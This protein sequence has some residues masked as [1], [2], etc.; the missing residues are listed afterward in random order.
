MTTL[1]QHRFL[2]FMVGQNLSCEFI[3]DSGLGVFRKLVNTMQGQ[4]EK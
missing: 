4:C 2:T 1:F 3:K